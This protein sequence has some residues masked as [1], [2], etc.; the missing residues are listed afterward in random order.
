MRS[1]PLIEIISRLEG[2]DV[3]DGARAM[4]R[5]MVLEVSAQHGLTGFDRG[6][7]LAHIRRLLALHVSRPT[8]RDRLIAH[9]GVS[10]RQA[11]RL[12]GEA[13]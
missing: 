7:Q 11:Y 2:L 3:D 1:A 5:T 6:E 12:I 9:Y 8:I 13:L 10:R 4:F